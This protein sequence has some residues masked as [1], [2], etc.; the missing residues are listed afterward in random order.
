MKTDSKVPLSSDYLAARGWR[1]VHPD[2][3]PE[4]TMWF[5][6]DRPEHEY[7]FIDALRQEWHGDEKEATK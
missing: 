3:H 7:Y 6:R 5:H 1:K 2:M 4:H